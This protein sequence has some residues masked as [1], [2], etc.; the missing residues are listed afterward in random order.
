MQ[1]REIK[2]INYLFKKRLQ[3]QLALPVSAPALTQ[4]DLSNHP[5][6]IQQSSSNHPCVAVTPL[7][8]FDTLGYFVY[9]ETEYR[10]IIKDA[11]QNE[12]QYF[13]FIKESLSKYDT[14]YL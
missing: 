9:I 1:Q 5:A 2:K 12:T 8:Q 14:T 10:N 6:I 7:H 4:Q 3:R 11:H 13:S